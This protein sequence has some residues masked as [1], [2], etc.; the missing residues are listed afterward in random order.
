MENVGGNGVS[1]GS[2]QYSHQGTQQQHLAKKK[3]KNHSQII[4]Y[5]WSCLCP[6]I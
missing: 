1:Y 2:Y 6:N 5:G 3:G 4:T